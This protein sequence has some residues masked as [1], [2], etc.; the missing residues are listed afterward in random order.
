MPSSNGDEKIVTEEREIVIAKKI[1][2]LANAV[3]SSILLDIR[4]TIVGIKARIDA[5]ADQRAG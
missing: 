3:T 2:S 4:T 1:G 5:P